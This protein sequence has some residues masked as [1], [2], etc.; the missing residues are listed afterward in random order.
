MTFTIKVVAVLLWLPPVKVC[1][2]T[3]SFLWPQNAVFN[4]FL[5][6][7][8]LFNCKNK[9][10]NELQ[11]TWSIPPAP[12]YLIRWP[13]LSKKLL[14][15]F[16]SSL[17][18]FNSILQIWQWRYDV[19]QNHCQ[20]H[21]CGVGHN[22]SLQFD[23]VSV[24]LSYVI[25]SKSFSL[26]QSSHLKC[27]FRFNVSPPM[28]EWILYSVHIS[29]FLLQ[30]TALKYLH[31]LPMRHIHALHVVSHHSKLCHVYFCPFPMS[32]CKCEQMWVD[33]DFNVS[34]QSCLRC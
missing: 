31:I 32:K 26:H 21:F 25:H 20:E 8:S 11:L 14:I 22:Y 30:T 4:S 6:I 12:F 3:V 19:L 29:L 33:V 5:L 23:T 34:S 27:S 16:D 7:E 9:N 2:P 10:R 17:L 1:W 13:I 28:Q 15:Y 24:C 18:F